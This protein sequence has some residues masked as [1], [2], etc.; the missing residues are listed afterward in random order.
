MPELQP[1]LWRLDFQTWL[2]LLGLGLALWLI[3]TYFPLLTQVLW[4]FFGALLVSLA[5]RPLADRLA[6]HR[7]PR[8]LTV[9]AV[10]LGVALFLTLV[11]SLLAPTIGAEITRLEDNGP[12]LLE[13]AASQIAAT[14][15]I[16]KLIPSTT[17]LLQNLG[18]RLD[19]VVRGAFSTVASLG[20]MA[21]D[22][23]V[24]LVIAFFLSSDATLGRRFVHNWLPRVYQPQFEG[25]WSRLRPRLTRW[26]WAQVGI[27][28]YFAVI[29][30]VGLAVLGVPFA[31]T[32]GLVGGMLEIIPYLGGFVAV[33]FAVIS[34]LTVRPLLAVWVVVYYLVVTEIESHV[35]APA[36]YGRIMGLHP[37]IVLFALLI[38]AKAGGVLGVLFAV[39]VTVVLAAVLQEV[40]TVWG[41]FESETEGSE[42]EMTEPQ[43]LSLP[44]EARDRTFS[45]QSEK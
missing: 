5:I 42:P 39:P 36:F 8:S 10:Y 12:A 26:I 41:A 7:V 21:L 22:V 31:F 13:K 45:T 14:P 35:I 32:I 17:V 25:V 6:R 19:V 4:V 40:R 28:L 33:F 20:G 24:M 29:F 37:A 3:I 1:R 18:Q 16:G 44:L 27:A 23:L 11:G 30:S 38:G 43:S 2:G 15:F 34:S 9:L